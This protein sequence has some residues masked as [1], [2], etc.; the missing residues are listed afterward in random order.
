MFLMMSCAFVWKDVGILRLVS[1]IGLDS[2][3]LIGWGALGPLP[4]MI[5][6]SMNIVMCHR[7]IFVAIYGSGWLRT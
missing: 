4:A 6:L 1:T 3:L 5:L 2:L 7:L